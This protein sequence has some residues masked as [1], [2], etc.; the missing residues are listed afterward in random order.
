MSPRIFFALALIALCPRAGAFA[1]ISFDHAVSAYENGNHAEAR[2][3]FERMAEA[4]MPEAQFN[5][6]VMWL[7]GEG[8]PV[9]RVKAALWIDTAS[10]AG[11]QPASQA[12]DTVVGVLDDEQR[13][14]FVSQRQDWTRE[15]SLQA[16]FQRHRARPCSD[17]CSSAADADAGTTDPAGIPPTRITAGHTSEPL[18]LSIDGRQVY[19]DRIAP[20]YPRRATERGIMGVVRLGGWIRPDGALEQPHVIGADPRGYFEEEALRAWKQWSFKWAEDEAPSSPIYI[21]QRI[22]FAL[23]GEQVQGQTMRDISTAVERAD[24]DPEAAYRALWMVEQFELPFADEV[25]VEAK[26]SVINQA[27][28]E[29]VRRAQIDLARR[30]AYGHDVEQDRAAA[31][32]WLK[33]AAF[34]GQAE[35]QFELARWKTLDPS[36]RA[37][38]LHAAVTGGFLPAVLWQIRSALDANEPD[39]DYVASLLDQLPREWRNRRDDAV[40]AQAHRIASGD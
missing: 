15:H 31:I 40:I 30:L 39:R 24:E 35:A 36:F 25:A 11:Y 21:T 3:A 27:A 28:M 14:E 26:T 19:I 2:I 10:G 38:L 33:Q 23:E 7:N 8:G 1:P 32:F 13:A 18:Q 16:L 5:L 37:D 29:G 22:V 17:E 12:R 20:S 34:E 6:G 9:D 4:G